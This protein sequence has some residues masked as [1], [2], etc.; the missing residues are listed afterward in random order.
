MAYLNL[1]PWLV[2]HT[3]Y[4]ATPLDALLYLLGSPRVHTDH[5]ALRLSSAG[6][7]FS[8]HHREACR[9]TSYQL[10]IDPCSGAGGTMADNLTLAGLKF[11]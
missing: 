2:F 11:A 5:D 9:R 3:E 1:E 6:K 4:T 10:Q 7:E 8:T